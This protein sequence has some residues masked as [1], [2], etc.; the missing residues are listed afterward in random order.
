MVSCIYRAPDSHI[1]I[2]C[3]WMEEKD[4][5]S[6]R[7]LIFICGDFNIDLLYPNKYRVI[8]KFIINQYH[9]QYDFMT[10]I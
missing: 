9:V 3:D 4:S 10:K 5:L 8:G 2:F 7:K 1:E 6:N